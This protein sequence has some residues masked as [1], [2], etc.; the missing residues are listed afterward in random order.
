MYNI[1]DKLWGDDIT[2]SLICISDFFFQ[3]ENIVKQCLKLIFVK[4]LDSSFLQICGWVLFV[5]YG[6]SAFLNFREF[7]AMGGMST[8]CGGVAATTT[9]TTTTHHS[10]TVSSGGGAEESGDKQAP[11]PYPG[12][13]PFE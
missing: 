9:T 4:F 2:N 13:G 12:G 11:P 8:V 5:L 3:S 7:M 1:Y 10:T 6:L